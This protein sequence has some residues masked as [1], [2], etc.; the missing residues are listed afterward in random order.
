MINSN[1]SHG[2]SVRSVL[3]DYMSQHKGSTL[4][5]VLFGLFWAFTLPYMSYLLG[6]IIDEL[7]LH[8]PGQADILSLVAVPLILF[9]S[10]HVLRSF[11]YFVHG[12]CSLSSIPAHKSRI[13][14]KLFHHISHQSIRYFEENHSGTLSSKINNASISVE[15]IVFNLFTFIYPQSIAILATGIMLS[16]VVPVYGLIL[17]L[18]GIAIIVYTYRA[19]KIGNQK[20]MQFAKAS[21]FLNGKIVDVMHNIQAVI[22]NATMT[23]ELNAL[24]RDIQTVVDEDRAMQKHMNKVMLVQ[25]IAMNALVFSYL[26]GSVIAYSRN[27]STIGEIVFVMTAVT[28]IAGLTNS[29]GKSFLDYVVQTGRLNEGISLFEDRHEIT[30][31]KKAKSHTMTKGTIDIKHINFAYPEQAN[32]FEDFELS[33][34]SKEKIGIVGGSGAGKTSLFKLIMRLYEPSS[35]QICIDDLSLD[36]YTKESLLSQMAIVPQHLTLFNR[37]VYDNIAY[38]CGECDK[39]KVIEAAKKSMCHDF[40]S[41]LPDGYETLIGEQGVKLSGGQRQR[42]AFA[43]A[44]LK[45]APILLLDEATSALDSSTEQKIQTGMENLWQDKTAL[46]IAHRLSTL[47][48]MDRIIVLEA[49]KIIESGT[50][51]ELIKLK[52]AYH[53]YWSHQSDGFIQNPNG[54]KS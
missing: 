12:F 51:D 18:W 22:H 44:I 30:D 40:I 43:R 25:H 11:G 26:F 6:Q 34:H 38:G 14:Q 46:V 5:F 20:A 8:P 53:S 49:G 41:A 31:S 19:A 1:K 27:T 10:I 3:I 42:I 17:W 29:L 21:S 35:G 39:E 24:E 52:G 4:F 48:A 33:I 9:V 37:S 15:P 2:Y 16:L 32:L 13:I 45:N 50:H 47:K 54:V 28:A 36:S 7:K 23:A